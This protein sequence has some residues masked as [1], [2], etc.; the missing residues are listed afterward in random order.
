MSSLVYSDSVH[1]V[2]NELDYNL[3]TFNFNTSSCDDSDSLHT[4]VLTVF[5]FVY[6]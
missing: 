4:A 2:V 6:M 1:I 5:F 3:Y